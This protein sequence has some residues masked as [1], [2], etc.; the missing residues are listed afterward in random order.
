MADFKLTPLNVLISKPYK[1]NWLIKDHMEQNS[2]GM[3]F[4]APA[5]AKSFIAMDIAFCIAAGIDWNGN[6]TEQGK[7]VYL[8]GEGFSGMGKRFKALAEKYQANTNEVYFSD[9]PAS[10]SDKENTIKVHE[11]IASV[12]PNPALIII[13]TL[14]RNFGVG[15]ENSAKD[16]GVFLYHITALMK[17]SGCAILI[18]HHS[19]HGD[20]DR[21]RGSSSIKAAMDVEYKITKAGEVVT[22]ACTKAKEFEEPQSMS[23]NLVSQS[24]PSWLDDAGN[25]VKSAILVSTTYS[26]P[27]GTASLTQRESQILQALNDAI[28]TNG[29]SASSELAAK[30]PEL[31]GRNYI[32]E[33]GW[34][35]EAYIALDQASG[36][37]NKPQANQ[38]AFSRAKGKLLHANKI[39]TEEDHYWLAA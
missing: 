3:L 26:A 32:H 20:A 1:P 15:D 9:L 21:G 36:G 31:T 29:K 37:A 17:G 23:F 30:Y 11:G 4:G 18:V 14:H 10:F 28:A 12:C 35:A 34:R 6:P 27:V 19:G 7:V 22:M 38:K 5:S 16:F 13:D 24:I 33:S 2:I 8:A 39:V 25:P